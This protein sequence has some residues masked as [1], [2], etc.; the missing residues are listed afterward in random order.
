VGFFVLP[1]I[2]KSQ[3]LKQ[4]PKITKRSAV[5]RQVKVN[6]WT[7]SL[8]VRG[9]ALTE[10]DDRPFMSW[11]ELYV[12]FQSSSIF[13]R[14]WTF[15]EIR[16]V[17]PF[18][19]L[20]LFKDGTLNFANMSEPQTNAPPPASPPA[21]LPRIT[22]FHLDITNGF[23]VWEDRT[24][25]SLFR[26][27]CRPIDLHLQRFNTLPNSDAP[28]SFSAHSDNGRSV[29]WSGDLSVQPL[30]SAGHLELTGVRLSKFQPYL[31]DAI[32]AV[33]TNGL[34]NLQ[35]DYLFEAATNGTQ[36]WIT[37]G[38][39][40]M[41]KVQAV[42][43]GSGE[44]VAGLGSLDLSKS[45][46]SLSQKTA[47]LGAVKLSEV[48]L[49]TR[50]DKAGRL[51]LLDLIQPASVDTNATAAPPST[52]S[53][54]FV[55]SVD[56]F[57]IEKSAVNFED[58]SRSDPFKTQLRPIEIKVKHFTTGADSGATYSF[59]IDTEAAERFEG[60]GRFS[61]NPL[62]STGEV[63]FAA[64][65]LK[66]YLPYLESFFRGKVTAGKMEIKIP[67]RVALQTNDT[68]AGVNNF[69]LKLTD[70]D[71]L[72]PENEE[73]VTHISEI[74]FN[75]V[76][77][78][79]ED[80][81]ARVGLFKGN[82][83][84][85]FVRR[86]KDGKINLGT[87]LAVSRTNTPTGPQPERDTP[88]PTSRTDGPKSQSAVALGGWILKV[89]EVDLDNYTVRFQDLQTPKPTSVLLDQ[90]DLNVKRVSTVSNA[91]LT[92]SLSMRVN[93]T[94]TLAAHGSA[95]ILPMS[96]E[97]EVAFTNL[98]LRPAQP[99]VDPFLGIN[100]MSGN[101][102]TTA[103][104]AFQTLDPAAP[105]FHILGDMSLDGFATTD[106]VLS[107]NFVR[108]DSFKLS[109]IDFA[110][111]PSHL[112]IAEVRL[113]NPQA[114][115]IVGPDRKSNLSTI[116][117]STSSGTNAVSSTNPVSVAQSPPTPAPSNSFPIE[118]DAI[119]LEKANFGFVDESIQP[120]A[121]VEIEDLSG[122][123]KGLSRDSNT[124]AQVNLSGKLG[125]Q[126]PFAISGR[127]NPLSSQ[128]FVDL[129]IS[130]A[131]T[132]LTPLTGYLEKYAGHP[133][134]KGR[135]ST[136]LSY[137]IEGK[138][139]KADNKIEID[140]LT[141]GPRNNSPD[142]TTL[143][144][145]LGI[146]LLKDADGRIILDLPV[147]GRLDDPQF[148]IGPIVL[149]VVMNMLV[150]A[151]ASPFKVLGALVGGGE[152]LAFVQ[153]LPG[154]TNVVQGELEKLDKLSKAL[155]HRPSLNLEIEGAVD[156]TIDG[157]A[158]AQQKL[159]QPQQTAPPPEANNT[160]KATPSAQNPGLTLP[161]YE[162]LL[163]V[164]LTAQISSNALTIA[165]TNP[166]AATRIESALLRGMPVSAEDYRQLMEA[167]ARYIQHFLVQTGKVAPDRLLLVTPKTVDT[168]YRG[169][170]RANLSLD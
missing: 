75:D 9:L 113:V 67:Y 121:A 85:I 130:N 32:R 43:P 51:N 134:R 29:T 128:M 99:Y 93:E 156:P 129:V 106:Q 153:F 28:Y 96:G 146:A 27:E 26:T 66:K 6:P 71:M 144:V 141:L 164:T 107:T 77:A 126:S 138:E 11:D 35:I 84:L 123:V 81:R 122:S 94:G 143:P 80:R 92:A 111:K 24:H 105:Q 25:R 97:F 1:P 160:G 88:R 90:V 10:P 41:E 148:K 69:S 64:M 115:L 150:K 47:R 133:L 169:Q 163:A 44:L 142:A 50:L 109:G 151:A 103:R 119:I 49:S 12:N 68:L 118:L 89:D 14:A 155:E 3:L 162:K 5:V 116:L 131:N 46:F 7:L 139:L 158:L 60:E 166:A 34:A 127:L 168:S 135:L 140:Q 38:A 45:E 132:Q 114:D 54:P 74:S 152:E 87:L 58:L 48:A 170:P 125:E 145:K 76:D 72:L 159:R 73:K 112:K 78:S 13:R 124:N 40:H 117:H 15:K 31:E 16:L 36:L 22:I 37:N 136:T 33:V 42:D 83:G 59:T 79:L 39:I 2:I 20:I 104:L 165:R 19:E 82:G 53:K 21:P 167:R 57:T 56:D 108:W 65:D 102:N 100:I 17:K 4:L 55:L 86:E 101:L 137:H 18:S 149:K 154:T 61:I 110:L 161:E 70:L 147:G 157:Q 30:R 91:P 8:T 120:P 23:F 62:Q 98:D 95:R 52:N 63:R